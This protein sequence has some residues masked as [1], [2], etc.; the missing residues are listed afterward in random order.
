MLVYQ[1]VHKYSNIYINQQWLG[2]LSLG[3]TIHRAKKDDEI[4]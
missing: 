4:K 2:V 1:R 3:D